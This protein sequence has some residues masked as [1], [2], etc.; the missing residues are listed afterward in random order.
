MSPE[1]KLTDVD[2]RPPGISFITGAPFAAGVGLLALS[3]DEL[4]RNDEPHSILVVKDGDSARGALVP[5]NVADV[6][7]ASDADG[8]RYGY[9]LGEDGGVWC[10]DGRGIVSSDGIES[11]RNIRA[12]RSL[13]LTSGSHV[14]AGGGSTV[15]VRRPGSAWADLDMSSVLER[16][17]LRYVGFEKVLAS[18]DG[19]FFLFGWSGVAVM[20]GNG[21]STVRLDLPT[22]LDLYDAAWGED[23][24]IY[25]CGDEGT[26]LRGRGIDDWS[27]I[28]NEITDEKL[29]GVCSFGGRV[30]VCSMHLIYEVVGSELRHTDYSERSDIPSFTYRLRSCSDC[31]WSI[32][33]KQLV[34]YDGS[35]WRELILLS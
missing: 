33:A 30:F 21:G 17:G 12:L 25:A 15:F 22:N 3:I 23:G 26:V 29:W 35:D 8:R 20:L 18:A 1:L 32:G 7:V 10:Y 4:F 2:F 19:S 5:S 24:Y 28:D 11:P 27:V 31:A 34:E 6:V 16:E 9:F 13:G 14:A